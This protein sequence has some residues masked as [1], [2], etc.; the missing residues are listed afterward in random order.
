[1]NKTRPI[2]SIKNSILGPKTVKFFI[3]AINNS[4]LTI[5][6]KVNTD[7]SICFLQINYYMI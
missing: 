1:M 6:N 7:V 5:Y 2:K 3:Q 4:K